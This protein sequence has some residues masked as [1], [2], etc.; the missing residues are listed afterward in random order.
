MAKNCRYES[1]A[2]RNWNIGPAVAGSGAR[3]LLN[4]LVRLLAR[5]VAGHERSGIVIARTLPRTGRRLA[6]EL[7]RQ[8]NQKRSA[9]TA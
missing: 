8:S 9:I 4:E 6:I 7:R 1:G 2:R 5:T 3:D